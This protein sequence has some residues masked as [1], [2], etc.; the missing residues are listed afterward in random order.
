MSDTGLITWTTQSGI[1]SGEYTAE[2]VVTDPLGASANQQLKVV[3]N[4][5]PVVESLDSVTVKIGG[6]VT[7]T[8]GATDP[9]GGKLTY[10]ALNIPDGFT[11]I[12]GNGLK[13]KFSWG[14]RKAIAGDHS[15][16]IEVVDAAGLK[17]I[18]SAQVTLNAN[19]A[20]T[21]EPIAP[22]AV[23]AGGVVEVQVVAADVDNDNSTLNYV[24]ED[25]PKGMQ[26]SGDGLIL[27]SVDNQAETV[28]Y[29]VTVIVVDADNAMSKQV[30]EVSVDGK[31]PPNIGGH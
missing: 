30:L 10:K 28:T 12:S 22:V 17:S 26:I 31:R 6:K 15:I 21:T 3:V 20:P 2:A 13:G 1:Y 11:E 25:A 24:L 7:F 9:E 16:T 23:D 14:T 19:I 18:I 5:A 8:V 4:G 27:W 29:S